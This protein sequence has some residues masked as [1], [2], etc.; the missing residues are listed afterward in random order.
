MSAGPSAF[1]DQTLADLQTILG[2]IDVCFQQN[3]T[4]ECLKDPK[5]RNAL[6]DTGDIV[7]LVRETAG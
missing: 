6:G 5:A 3:W 1:K 4:Q 2:E 7:K